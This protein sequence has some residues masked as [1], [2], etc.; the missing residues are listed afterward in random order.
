MFYRESKSENSARENILIGKFIKC[1]SGYAKNRQIRYNSSSG[2]VITALL[3]FALEKQ[4][5]TGAIVVRQKEDDI[6]QGESFIARTKEEIIQSQKSKYVPIIMRDALKELSCIKDNDK[7]AV[8]GLPCQFS[9]IEKAGLSSKSFLR[10]GLFC[11]HTPSLAGLSL[12]LNKIARVKK[13]EIS[14]IDFR[15]E[16]WPGYVSI[17]KK[18]GKELKFPF[19]FFWSIVGSRFFYPKKCLSC[20]DCLSET[21]D[22]SFG[23]AWLKEFKKDNLGQS[24]IVARTQRG[25]DLLLE[26]EKEGVIE[27]SPIPPQK[28]IFSQITTLYVKKKLLKYFFGQKDGLKLGVLDRLLAFSF[29]VS[30]FFAENTVLKRILYI[31][32]K[33]F[34]YLYEG[35]LG[36]ICHRKA[37]HDFNDFIA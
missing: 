15:G 31:L 20:S 5:I 32:P 7:I 36:R 22:I 27:I 12:F 2:G 24:L 30:L 1:Y 16:G 33:N 26:A 21:S 29:F 25:L 18:D 34:F 35:F 11:G 4:I 28:V 10:F 13:K 9:A 17:L 8:V 3:A 19:Q 6:F 37:K 23:D 14:K